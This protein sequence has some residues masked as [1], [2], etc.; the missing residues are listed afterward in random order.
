V[1]TEVRGVLRDSAEPEK[2]ERLLRVLEQR[3]GHALMAG[4]ES[5]K[6]DLSRAD[7]ARLNLDDSVA[8][9]SLE[10][11]GAELEAV[12]ADSLQRIR[13]RIDD[14]LRMAGLTTDSVSAVFLTGGSFRMPSVRKS[15][16]VP[17]LGYAQHWRGVFSGLVG[18]YQRRLGAIGAWSCR[19]ENPGDGRLL[20]CFDAI[21]RRARCARSPSF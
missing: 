3:T 4:V 14:V 6:I 1:L 19:E 7:I 10:I 9:I 16:E 15:S 17:A 12:V 5:A 18:K 13:S 2:I 21:E 11:T 8:D 20:V